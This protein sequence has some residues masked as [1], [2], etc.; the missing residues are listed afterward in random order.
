MF[1]GWPAS[2]RQRDSHTRE[3]MLSVGHVRESRDITTPFAPPTILSPLKA[4]ILLPAS[5]CCPDDVMEDS[6]SSS[7]SA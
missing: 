7:F 2:E 6:A 5:G 3:L 4:W 1:F